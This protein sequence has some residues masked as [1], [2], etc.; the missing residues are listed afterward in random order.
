MKI[1]MHRIRLWDLP[2]RVFHW[3]LVILVAAAIVS[4]Q[5]GGNAMLWHGRIGLAVVGLLAFRMAWGVLGSNHA[6]FANFVPTP[7]SV[8]AYLAG[9]WRGVGHNP[10]GAL[11]VLGLLGLL[12]LQAGTGLLASDDIAFRGPL[13]A[14]VGE[15]SSAR[16]TGLHKQV[17]SLLIALIVVHVAAIVFYAR[18]KKEN[19]LQPMLTGWKDTDRAEARSASGGGVLAF[20]AALLFALACVY[21]ASGAW[22]PPPPPAPASTPAP[23]W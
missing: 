14:L 23:N 16:L 15:D 22:I 4:G 3:A 13:Y 12:L 11:S 9:Q 19:L 18:V 10:L 7:S 1:K 6:R 17:S 5:N 8:R 20:I 2:V 21:G